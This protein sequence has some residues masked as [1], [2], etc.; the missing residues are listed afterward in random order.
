MDYKLL[1]FGNRE[2]CRPVCYLTGRVFVP[3]SY[4]GN[5]VF[6]VG[7]KLN[8]AVGYGIAQVLINLP[9]IVATRLFAK[10]LWPAGS[11]ERMHGNYYGNVNNEL[12]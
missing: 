8:V 7:C 10:L 9:I 12:L 5:L 11:R 1:Q 3:H 6:I 2:V 4:S